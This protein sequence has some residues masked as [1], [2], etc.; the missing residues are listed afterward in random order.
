MPQP[1]TGKP[2]SDA[3]YEAIAAAVAETAR[4]RWF[5]TE[6]ARRNRHTDT[7]LV[8]Q[9][10]E[11]IERSLSERPVTPQAE[12][13]IRIDLIEMANAIERTKS[14][15]AAIKPDGEG[16]GKIGDATSELDSIVEATERATS[17]ILAAA[18]RVQ[19]IAWTLREQGIDPAVCDLLDQYATE[20][21]TACSFQDLTGQRTR[22]VVE[23]LHFLEE[24][25][26]AMTRIW[27]LNEIA[28]PLR[29]AITSKPPLTN[30]QPRPGEG[31]MQV[32]VDEVLATERSEGVTQGKRSNSSGTGLNDKVLESAGAASAPTPPAISPKPSPT[33]LATGTKKN[34]VR[35]RD[36]IEALSPAERLALFT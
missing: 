32:E 27:R 18:E 30:G 4:G 25:L 2:L 36:P 5:L 22:K 29:E 7:K 17:D 26:D 31:L 6:H 20:I 3:D 28:T 21:Y 19:E 35:A 10:I 12:E 24:R 11:K 33:V 9:A 15:I 16:S 13:K 14:E 23:V 8:L 34:S 1:P